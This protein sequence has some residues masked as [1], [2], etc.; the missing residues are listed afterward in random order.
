V[1]QSIGNLGTYYMNIGEYETAEK[2]Y[3]LSLEIK[4]N[5]IGETN[6]E[7][8]SSLNNLSIIYRRLMD[9]KNAEILLK[10]S[11]EIKKNSPR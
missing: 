2:L 7:F 1:G 9:Y 6:Y 3:K 11:L 5:T 8:A 4:K 10:R